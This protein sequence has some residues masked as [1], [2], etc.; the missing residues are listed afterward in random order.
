MIDNT[1]KN[2][3]QELNFICS[4]KSIEILPNQDYVD[5]ITPMNIKCEICGFIWAIKPKR[6][7]DTCDPWGGCPICRDLK[8]KI[9]YYNSYR[10]IAESRDIEILT[11]FLGYKNAKTSLDLKCK[12]CGHE[13]SIKPENIKSSTKKHWGG[14]PSCR[15]R[16]KWLVRFPEEERERVF[17]KCI[18][19]TEK[20][21]IKIISDRYNTAHIP[22]KYKCKIC[23]FEWEAKPNHSVLVENWEGCPKCKEE[24]VLLEN[25]KFF[26]DFAYKHNCKIIS[27]FV[28]WDKEIKF[29]CKNCQY[30]WSLLP[31]SVKFYSEREGIFCP[32]CREYEHRCLM[33]SKY[34][35][36]GERKY[37]ILLSE[38][39]DYKNNTTKLLWKCKICRQIFRK[40]FANMRKIIGL[41]CPAC[42]ENT[43][44]YIGEKFCIKMLEKILGVN[45]SRH[46]RFSWLISI[47]KYPLHL[48]GYNDL[49]KLAFEY[50]GMQHY[51]FKP[52]FHS[53]YEKFKTLQTN[54]IIKIKLCRLN[55][56]KLIV[57]PYHIKFENMER[58][59]KSKLD[60]LNIPHKNHSIKWRSLLKRVR[61][62]CYKSSNKIKDILTSL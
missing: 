53:A 6:M 58:F 34:R 41:A 54:D 7:K 44:D 11:P 32:K 26:R 28:N 39:G 3:L 43:N 23:G 36:I 17:D 10:R 60:E 1:K 56:V 21:D 46:K 31:E 8:R 47:K 62:D 15:G 33:L 12:I 25:I 49:L 51:V 37:A 5:A 14:C 13:W 57:V 52:F 35:K 30:E 55:H 38:I 48:D 16:I 19:E 24:N 29:I 2:Y 40:S 4:K 59:L 50:N 18:K 61:L 22:L 27:N 42:N 20:R 45:F 9:K